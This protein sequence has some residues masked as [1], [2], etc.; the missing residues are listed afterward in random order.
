MPSVRGLVLISRLDY[1]E[2]R[3]GTDI[4]REFLRKISTESI[5]FIRQPLE[6]AM[7]YPDTMLSTI[8]QILLEDFFNSEVQEFKTLGKWSANN[9]MYRC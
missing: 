6:S 8:D 4:Q 9:F 2:M 7:S 5:N 1:L 3:F